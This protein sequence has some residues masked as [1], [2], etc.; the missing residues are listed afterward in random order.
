MCLWGQILLYF[1]LK[2]G[3]YLEISFVSPKHRPILLVFLGGNFEFF[4]HQIGN[5]FKKKSC[6]QLI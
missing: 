3:E 1:L 4:N 5:F 2:I 6:P